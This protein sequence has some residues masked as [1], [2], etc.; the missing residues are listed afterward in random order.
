MVTCIG[1]PI[2]ASI[3]SAAMTQKKLIMKVD[4]CLET[5]HLTSKKIPG[6]CDINTTNLMI[7]DTV[8]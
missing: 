5:V 2:T 7:R 6:S 4:F 1:V 3:N 8:Q